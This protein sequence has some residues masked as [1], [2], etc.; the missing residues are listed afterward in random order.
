MGSGAANFLMNI[1]KNFDI[2]SGNQ[3]LLSGLKL[4][5]EITV[6]LI[7]V[8]VP[9]MYWRRKIRIALGVGNVSDGN[10]IIDIELANLNN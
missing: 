10:G 2:L 4:V 5:A 7:T 3:Q 8:S 1:L 9:L 6:P